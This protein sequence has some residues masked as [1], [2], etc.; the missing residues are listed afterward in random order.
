MVGAGFG[1]LANSYLD[2]S[3]AQ[4]TVIS[5]TS[6]QIKFLVPGNAISGPV[7]YTNLSTNASVRSVQYIIVLGDTDSSY[8]FSPPCDIVG[9][10][11]TYGAG[12]Y[13]TASSK[14]NDQ[15]FSSGTFS[16]FDKDG[17]L[18]FIKIQENVSG[19]TG[20]LLYIWKNNNTG[21]DFS[22]SNLVRVE[23][24]VVENAENVSI[25]DANSDGKQ[26]LIV[27]NA[28][29]GAGGDNTVTVLINDYTTSQYIFKTSF[30]LCLPNLDMVKTIDVTGDGMEDVIGL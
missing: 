24:Q 29:S 30:D 27:T 4:A 28:K 15:V 25:F 18:Y 3:S 17:D 6:T 7:R 20:S 16:D 5:S 10:R 23:R 21:N 26:D 11:N 22:A 19:I 1:S 2:L 12:V 8:V 13:V 9:S 14:R